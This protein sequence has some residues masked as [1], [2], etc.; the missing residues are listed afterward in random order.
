MMKKSVIH[1]DYTLFCGIYGSFMEEEKYGK[2]FVIGL[3]KCDYSA[4][5]N[6][7]VYLFT[8]KGKTNFRKAR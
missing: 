1:M 4:I 5:L 8:I 6:L 3:L 2:R 7:F